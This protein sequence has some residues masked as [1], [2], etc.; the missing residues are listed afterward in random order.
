MDNMY[1]LSYWRRYK[2]NRH[3]KFGVDTTYLH[4]LLSIIH[5]SFRSVDLWDSFKEIAVP[6]K[7][8]RIR[9]NMYAY[10]EISIKEMCEISFKNYNDYESLS[11]YRRY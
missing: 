7:N 3:V 5:K 1:S 9:I 2:T 4:N 11:F 8:P 6:V 10:E